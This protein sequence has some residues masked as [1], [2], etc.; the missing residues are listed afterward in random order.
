MANNLIISYDLDTTN[1]RNRDYQSV[2]DA[3]A[4][5]GPAI[6]LEFSHFYVDSEHSAF[7]AAHVVWRTMSLGDKLVVVDASKNEIEILGVSDSKIRAVEAM[8]N[9]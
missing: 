8:W 7:E 1:E 4:S 3:I 9:R 6:D 5:L 2:R